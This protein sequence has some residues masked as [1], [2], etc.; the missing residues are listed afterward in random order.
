MRSILTT[1]AM[2]AADRFAIESGRSGEALM[3][4]AGAGAAD[5]IRA[6]WAPRPTAVLCGPGNNGGDGFV[7]ARRLA[8]AGWPVTVF[9]MKPADALAGDAAA[10]AAKWSGVTRPLGDAAPDEYGLVVDA[11]FGAGLSR[12]LEDDAARLADEVGRSAAAV[13]AIDVP[14]GI[15]GD[16]ARAD[17]AAFRADLTATFHQFKPAHVLEPGASAC[18]EIVLVDIGVP[19]GWRDSVEIAAELN[20]PG[21]WT[22]SGLA[23]D[24]ATHKHRRGR[25]CVLSGPGGA[26]GA[27]RLAAQAGLSAG[28]GFVTLLCPGSAL[29]EA[30]AAS[31]AVVTRKL[32]KDAAFGDVLG[33]HRADAAV[34]GPGAGVDETTQ[35]RA[36]SA[37]ASGVPLVLDADALTVFADA[38][39]VFFS[40]LR[41]DCVLTPHAGE[42]ERLFPG[43]SQG[44]LDKIEAAR[45]AAAECGAVIVFKGPDTVI[46][47]PDGR[48]RV[49]TH[50]SPRLAS[51]GTGDVLAG[52]I[53]AFIAQGAGAFDA[54][55][56]AV[57]IHGDA[58]RRMRPGETAGDLLRRLPESLAAL[59]ARVRRQAA[60]DRLMRG[61]P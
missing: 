51:A 23:L 21:L 31:L 13:V 22:A 52:M 25:L 17:G 44:S 8:E 4:A 3:E 18:G 58:G 10:A 36:L 16:R 54:A 35:E 57:W 48:V 42:F 39:H 7:V 9:A 30:A 46:A 56:A 27:A 50:A 19:D 24:R 2:G 20:D 33:D 60:L 37:L 45:R 61:R 32:P 49:N 38:S 29:L 47:A 26:T 53:G 5:A 34:L 15:H 28:A 1:E 11:L 55:S 59:A 41:E 40:A 43:L 14:S 12:P 6:R